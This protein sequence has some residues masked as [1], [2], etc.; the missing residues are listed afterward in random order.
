MSQDSREFFEA[1]AGED[2][3]TVRALLERDPELSAA[4]DEEGRSGLLRAIYGGN[5]ELVTLLC[6]YRPEMDIFE[7]AA[8]GNAA[9]VL[10]LVREEPR[11]AHFTSPDGFGPLGLAAFFGSH[12]AVAT[13]LR[14]GASPNVASKN[15]MRVTPLHS[16][17]AHREPE[18]SAKICRELLARGADPDAR[19]AGGWTPL[20]QAAA[21]GNRRLVRLLLRYGADAAPVSE[22]GRTPE[23]LARENDHPEV[24]E[25]LSRAAAR[26]G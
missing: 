17:A 21:H 4:R 12:A 10:E 25:L 2:L 20:H 23:D 13:L 8:A 6:E 1:I 3:E 5:L 7:A 24:V 26:S 22:D 14:A 19:Q 16:G 11:R 9:R 18:V 15:A